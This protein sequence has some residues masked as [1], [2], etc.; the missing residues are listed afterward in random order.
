MT[1]RTLLA[2]QAGYD[3]PEL[4]PEHPPGSGECVAWHAGKW[5]RETGRTRPRDYARHKGG[6]IA[7]NDMVVVR[8]RKTGAFTRES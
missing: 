3:H 6:R 7:L 8:S 4:T 5:L 2:A 1:A